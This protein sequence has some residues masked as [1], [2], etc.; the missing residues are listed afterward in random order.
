MSREY[1][2]E[3][4]HFSTSSSIKIVH[5]TEEE[6]EQGVTG[7]ITKEYWFDYTEIR[8]LY[9]ALKKLEFGYKWLLED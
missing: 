2:I 5:T 4:Y 7:E 6:V 9:K 3:L 1:N 8:N